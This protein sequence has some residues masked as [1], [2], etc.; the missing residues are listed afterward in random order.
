[1]LYNIDRNPLWN[2]FLNI[3]CAFITPSNV[4]VLLLVANVTLVQVIDSAYASTPSSVWHTIMVLPSA[5]QN[6]QKDTRLL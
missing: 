5:S 6:A 4:H 2:V 3:F 1:M